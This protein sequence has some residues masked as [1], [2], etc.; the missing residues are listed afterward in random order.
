MKNEQLTDKED[1]CDAEQKAYMKRREQRNDDEQ[2]V[3]QAIGLL[4]SQIRTLK[5]YINARMA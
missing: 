5:K 3:S 2:V 4:T 1:F